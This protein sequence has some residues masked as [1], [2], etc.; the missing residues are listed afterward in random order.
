MSVPGSEDTR[1]VLAMTRHSSKADAGKRS[2][3]DTDRDP[4]L[5]PSPEQLP[6]GAEGGDDSPSAD[7]P[8]GLPADDGTPLGDTDQHSSP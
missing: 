1:R 6:G 8:P 2:L 3:E 4:E 7:R 5:R